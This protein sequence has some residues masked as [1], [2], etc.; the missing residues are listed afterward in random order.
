MD[1]HNGEDRSGDATRTNG[2]SFE[3][4]SAKGWRQTDEGGGRPSQ[5]GRC[6]AP[7]LFCQMVELVQTVLST[8]LLPHGYCLPGS[9]AEPTRGRGEGAE[10]ERQ[11]P[12]GGGLPVPEV[13]GRRPTAATAAVAVG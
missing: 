10:G 9:S 3:G 4:I 8:S 7:L 6:C 13:G 5:G 2:V 1:G 12:G 11:R